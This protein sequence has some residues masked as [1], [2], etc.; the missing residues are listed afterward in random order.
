MAEYIVNGR[1]VAGVEAGGTVT[2]EQLG[3]KAPIDILLA[4]GHIT[5]KPTKAATV[6]QSPKSKKEG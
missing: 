1:K 2:T 6:T 3:P 4:A 5:L